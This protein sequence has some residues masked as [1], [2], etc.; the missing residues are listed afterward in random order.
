MDLDYLAK[1]KPTHFFPVESPVILDGCIIH[2]EKVLKLLGINIDKI[3]YFLIHTEDICQIA[4]RQLSALGRL[5]FNIDGKAKFAPLK[6]FILSHFQYCAAV[7]Y[8]CS[9]PNVGCM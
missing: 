5:S 1:N 3:V 9:A 8:H 2:P 6:A 4:G 7:W